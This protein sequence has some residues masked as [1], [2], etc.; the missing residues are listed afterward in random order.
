[1]KGG[2][3]LE[4][5]PLEC[6]VSA[7]INSEN[8]TVDPRQPCLDGLCREKDQCAGLEATATR[9]R[10]TAQH[11]C[12]R[13]LQSEHKPVMGPLPISNEALLDSLGAGLGRI[14]VSS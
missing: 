6:V 13:L 1:M 4:E 14:N 10:T 5:K 2:F 8:A 9:S 11:L 12:F 7:Y 3:F